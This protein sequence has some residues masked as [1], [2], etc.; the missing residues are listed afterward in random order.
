MDWSEIIFISIIDTIYYIGTTFV[1]VILAYE[2]IKRENKMEK[3][4]KGE[5]K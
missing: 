3:R 1:G 4:K 5:K 2:L